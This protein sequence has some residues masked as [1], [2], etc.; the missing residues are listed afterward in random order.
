M[1]VR[2]GGEDQMPR[3][4]EEGSCKYLPKKKKRRGLDPFFLRRIKGGWGLLLLWGE[5]KLDYISQE[6]TQETVSL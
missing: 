6:K 3:R 5:K 1:K 2:K 4:G